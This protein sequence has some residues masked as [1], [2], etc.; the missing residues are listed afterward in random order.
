[1]MPITRGRGINP[2]MKKTHH[3]ALVKNLKR[4]IDDEAN[5]TNQKQLALDSGLHETAVRDILVGRSKN[6]GIDTLNALART[7]RM[8]I[9]ELTGEKLSHAGLAEERAAWPPAGV[10]KGLGARH[11]IHSP[12]PGQLTL[13]LGVI[14]EIDVRAGAG[15]GG[16]SP[17]EA[18]SPNGRDVVAHDAVVGHWQMP[19][20]YLSA[21]LR[22]A[23]R[24]VRIIAVEGDSM[25]PTLMSGDRVMVDIRR[26]V[27]SPPG[28]FAIWD[29][30]GVCVKRIELIHGSEPPTVR[31][32]S[33]NGQHATYERTAEEANIIGRV[34]W[35]GR[36][37]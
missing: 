28:V 7:M 21:E 6:P 29:G 3:P 19:E 20:G 23:P 36:R 10:T 33:D 17:L 8:D 34:I 14:P 13:D 27:P 18:F 9:N 32:I 24:T 1:M 15:M 30:L 12:S 22:A 5:G 16:E 37:V 11:K 31:I 4:Y 26:R 25:A 2:I 35:F